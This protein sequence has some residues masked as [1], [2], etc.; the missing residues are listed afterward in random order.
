MPAAP[1]L[2]ESVLK[3]LAEHLGECATGGRIDE[4]FGS[5]GIAD[6]SGQSTKWRR[7]YW[8]FKELQRRDSAATGVLAFVGE[9]MAPVR[10][11]K[12]MAT[13]EEHREGLNRILAF[14]GIEYGEDGK[15]R[16]REAARTLSQADD[17]VRR[18]RAKFTGRV[19]HPEVLKYCRAEMMQDNYFHAVLE[20]TKGLAQRIRDLSGVD[21][22]GALL[23]D[24]VFSGDRP[25]LALNSLQ[26]QTERS[27]QKG[28]ASLLKG[29]FGAIRNPLAHEPKILWDGEDDT[30]DYLSLVSLLHRKLD[31]CVPT[32]WV[33]NS[34]GN[35]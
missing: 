21:G 12:E 4:V 3:P 17:R 27:E 13:F 34:S 5:Q 24:R 33:T 28:L 32:G 15:F 22:D 30:A 35:L 11:S 29:C 26:T 10:Y 19:L 16:P 31:E 7:L 20:A 9:Y 23:V 14:S 6:G 25:A 1:P 2:P 8:A 18:I